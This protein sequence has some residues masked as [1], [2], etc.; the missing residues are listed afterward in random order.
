[1]PYQSGFDMLQQCE[2][3]N[4]D[5]V[6]VTA[7]DHYAIKAI[8]FSALDYL[9]KPVDLDE[10]RSAIMK[11]EKKQIQQQT[12]HKQIEVLLSNLHSSKN[13]FSVIG[14]PQAT[15]TIFIHVEEI[16]RVESKS[17]YCE[18]T[19]KDGTKKTIAKTLK[20]FEEL[21]KEYKFIRVHKSHLVHLEHIRHYIRNNP[22][23]IILSNDEKI[24]ISRNG[25]EILLQNISHL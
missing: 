20:E 22:G 24:E 12:L 9:L 6:F 2:E 11:V 1:M 5:I 18:L 10:L 7:H 15:G 4:F 14:L 23:H 16:I 8:K 19:M 3:I 21:L 17:N 13:T 25:R